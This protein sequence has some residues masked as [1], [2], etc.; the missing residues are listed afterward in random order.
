MKRPLLDERDDTAHVKRARR[1]PPPPIL[2]DG[3]TSPFGCED[4]IVEI[5]S[6]I[7][8]INDVDE[9]DGGSLLALARTHRLAW[10][11]LRGRLAKLLYNQDNHCKVVLLTAK[12]AHVH[13]FLWLTST[14]AWA[15]PSMTWLAGRRATAMRIVL[16]G[17]PA[18]S[19][20]V[21][22]ILR[23]TSPVALIPVVLERLRAWD[24]L[25]ISEPLCELVFCMLRI[26]CA[27]GSAWYDQALL[28]MNK[29]DMRGVIDPFV[30]TDMIDA[31]VTG[32]RDL[33]VRLEKHID[34]P[35]TFWRRHGLAA[36]AQHSVAMLDW[37]DRFF[38]P[39][40][41]GLQKVGSSQSVAIYE[42][43]MDP[44]VSDTAFDR[45]CTSWATPARSL[46]DIG[47]MRILAVLEA[48]RDS[49]LQRAFPQQFGPLVRD[50]PPAIRDSIPIMLTLWKRHD[51]KSP[52]IIHWITQQ[53][54]SHAIL[55]AA[56]NLRSFS[57]MDWARLWRWTHGV[58]HGGPDSFHATPVD[59]RLGRHT[60]YV[61]SFGEESSLAAFLFAVP[62]EAYTT[63]HAEA[64]ALVI[65]T[66]EVASDCYYYL[67]QLGYGLVAN[68]CCPVFP[69]FM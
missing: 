43:I 39:V 10:K 2:V 68:S 38:D 59:T 24:L 58:I 22:D 42:A 28:E 63:G 64:D 53:F 35:V 37:A 50:W 69:S 62:L 11:A 48:G 66:R 54:T 27:I 61:R 31:L 18:R 16:G 57:L 23:A 15:M 19:E 45:L 51:E 30:T 5:A 67:S 12:A 13:L 29:H 49:R 41:P 55:S 6:W 52:S 20:S 14:D 46:N 4:V 33:V 36:A 44:A 40:D 25:V 26:Q 56:L 32:D 17:R 8:V 7:T 9:P 1:A 21:M 60:A 3:G 47:T 65:Q 34:D